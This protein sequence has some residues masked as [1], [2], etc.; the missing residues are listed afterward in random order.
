MF[1]KTKKFFSNNAPVLAVG[2]LLVGGGIIIG[3][4]I[5]QRDIINTLRNIIAED[6]EGFLELA[7]LAVEKG[8]SMEEIFALG[9]TYG[10]TLVPQ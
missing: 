1:D 8:A 5:A 9:K 7:N 4:A 6:A 10:F 3:L 2:G